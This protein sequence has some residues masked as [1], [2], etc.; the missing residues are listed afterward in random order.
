MW[1]M[2]RCLL[3]Q[4]F[5]ELCGHH[6]SKVRVPVR[7]GVCAIAR[8]ASGTRCLACNT[9]IIKHVTQVVWRVGPAAW[10]VERDG[11]SVSPNSERD[12]PEVKGPCFAP[13][14]PWSKTSTTDYNDVSAM[15]RS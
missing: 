12:W 11:F 9:H 5:D 10:P 6:G 7:Q 2:I 4:H 1:A 13:S 8:V 3:L 14:A 15:H